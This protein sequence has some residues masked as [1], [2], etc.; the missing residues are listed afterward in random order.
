LRCVFAQ[1]LT[2]H[3]KARLVLVDAVER[4]RAGGKAHLACGAMSD[5]MDRVKPPPAPEHLRDLRVDVA[6]CGIDKGDFPDLAMH[7]G[8]AVTLQCGCR[9]KRVG[10]GAGPVTNRSRLRG[11][12]QRGVSDPRQLVGDYT[13]PILKPEAAEVVKKYGE[14]ELSG[15]GALRPDQPVLARTGA[16]HFFGI[17]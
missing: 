17:L 7:V 1:C 13:N 6:D 16:L 14:M 12:P 2:D 15:V 9:A 8:H 3:G 11:G 10:P 4:Q 5:D